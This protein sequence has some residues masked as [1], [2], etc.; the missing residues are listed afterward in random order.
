MYTRWTKLLKTLSIAI[1]IL[2]SIVIIFDS[3]L[4]I[5][6]SLSNSL[7]FSLLT[8]LLALCTGIFAIYHTNSRKI[9]MYSGI[10]SLWG[11]YIMLHC[12]CNDGEYYR[13]LYLISGIFYL[14]TLSYLIRAQIISNV[15]IKNILLCMTIAQ[16]I[17]MTGQSFNIINAYS[18][19]FP[20][21]GTNENPNVNAIFLLCCIPI[22]IE[23]IKTANKTFIYKIILGG[24]I[25]FLF[26]LQCRTAYIGG[27]VIL[28]TYLFSSKHFRQFWQKSNYIRRFISLSLLCA[29]ILFAGIYFFI[30][31]K[32]FC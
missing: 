29:T 31:K 13:S 8:S 16:L 7:L 27:I 30:N 4:F 32:E 2:I 22:L 9:S 20:I 21:T 23:R 3:D 10:A 1:L 5:Y 6:P 26:I 15:V 19:Y 18:K 11:V 24:I 14:I 17:F 12:Y 25:L 28:A